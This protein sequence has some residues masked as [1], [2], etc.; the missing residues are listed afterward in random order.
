[1]VIIAVLF[2]MG[3][4]AMAIDAFWHGPKIAD[5]ISLSFG[6]AFCFFCIG[7]LLA[8]ES[9]AVRESLMGT[10]AA[11]CFVIA[12]RFIRHAFEIKRKVGKNKHNNR[13]H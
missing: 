1:M 2:G 9:P 8:H 7:M 11:F 13:Q 4:I 12:L 6:Y 3:I 10:F 5:S